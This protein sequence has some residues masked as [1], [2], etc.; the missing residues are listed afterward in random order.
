MGNNLFNATVQRPVGEFIDW[1]VAAG[2]SIYAYRLRGPRRHRKALVDTVRYPVY[3]ITKIDK[4]NRAVPLRLPAG[5][6]AGPLCD[7]PGLERVVYWLPVWWKRRENNWV[8]ALR[9]TGARMVVKIVSATLKSE[10]SRSGTV[11]KWP[12][13]PFLLAARGPGVIC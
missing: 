1:T 6:Q 2:W 5:T 8:K 4:N 12:K 10:G 3:L 11:R 7:P 9:H 13:Y